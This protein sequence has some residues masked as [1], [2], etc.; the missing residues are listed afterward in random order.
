MEKK[1]NIIL[2]ANPKGGGGKTTTAANLAILRLNSVGDSFLLVDADSRPSISRW[3]SERNK[4]DNLSKIT[5]INKTGE[6]IKNS[7]K[8]LSEKYTDIIIDS[9]RAGG[10]SDSD[11]YYSMIVSTKVIIPLPPSQLDIWEL[12]FMNKMVASAKIVNPHLE[13]FVLPNKMST[14]PRVNELVD[15]RS[16]IESFDNF[17]IMDAFI[18]ERK[19]FR[20]AVTRSLSIIEMDAKDHSVEKGQF[21]IY[22]VYKEIYNEQI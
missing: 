1:K 3:A 6:D 10:D 5:C 21:E 16:T 2:I 14:N 18:S 8:A 17:K 20:D 12:S 15:I 19:A 13:A 4:E 7:V 22:N 11:L 9:G